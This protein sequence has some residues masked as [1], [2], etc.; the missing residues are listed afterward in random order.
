MP[1]YLF[2]SNPLKLGGFLFGKLAA[3][4]GWALQ[5]G[6]QLCYKRKDTESQIR[7]QLVFSGEHKNDS[8]HKSSKREIGTVKQS[9]YVE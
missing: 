8:V 1:T 3:C 6:L 7:L 2:D 9:V 4:N 5:Y